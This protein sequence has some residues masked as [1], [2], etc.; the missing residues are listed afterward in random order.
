M[1]HVVPHITLRPHSGR[2]ADHLPPRAQSILP[3]AP[4]RSASMHARPSVTH[5]PAVW[6][7]LSIKPCSVCFS[8]TAVCVFSLQPAAAVANRQL[9][10]NIL[11]GWLRANQRN[12]DTP[13]P[14]VVLHVWRCSSWLDDRLYLFTL[15]IKVTSGWVCSAE[16]QVL[17]YIKNITFYYQNIKQNVRFGIHV[18]LFIIIDAFIIFIA[19]TLQLEMIL[20][21]LYIS[22]FVVGINKVGLS[23]DQ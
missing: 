12:S 23:L 4:D 17:Y 21:T 13:R 10:V 3:H 2:P 1:V 18:L 5:V 19:L 7:K 11:V 14:G 20:I 16:Y 15:F 8:V 6:I 9:P 22:G